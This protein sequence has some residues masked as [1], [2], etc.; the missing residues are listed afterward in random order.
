MFD[1]FGLFA[2]C[3]SFVYAWFSLLS[4][5]VINQRTE[6]YV[7]RPDLVPG[8]SDYELAHAPLVAT[9]ATEVA[10][11]DRQEAGV[12]QLAAAVTRP[13][14]PPRPPPISELIAKSR[15]LSAAPAVSFRWTPVEVDAGAPLNPSEHNVEAM[16]NLQHM[17][18]LDLRST[19]TSL[20]L[21][22]PSIARLLTHPCT[23]PLR[24]FLGGVI[25]R[26]MVQLLEEHH[27]SLER[28]WVSVPRT[29]DDQLA[30]L[31]L[32][33]KLPSLTDL[34]LTRATYG[35]NAHLTALGNCKRLTSLGLR[36]N[37]SCVQGILR[38]LQ[39]SGSR[40]R[41]LRLINTTV[42]SGWSDCFALV[43]TL[44]LL[45]LDR[46]SRPDEIIRAI[47][48]HCPA[49]HTLQ[50]H[51]GPSTND[52]ASL[53]RDAT[54]FDTLLSSER[55]ATRQLRVTLALE[56]LQS[57]LDAHIASC[58][59]YNFGDQTEAITQEWKQ[60]RKALELVASRH[61]KQIRLRLE[62]VSNN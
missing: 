53:M 2:G 46:C 58:Q 18:E 31:D 30:V 60:A 1:C 21:Q 6:P 23:K 59:R 49:M 10:P 9:L 51:C 11:M 42:A 8:S 52:V 12:N 22:T 32:L 40:L 27:P 29:V 44:E 50:I 36:G 61:P 15:L 37:V 24:S 4:S 25:N 45:C 17:T 38:G 57:L 16:L 14:E 48:T 35:A 26:Q 34:Q 43:P 56:P 3:S 20:G 33:P 55:D 47:D 28:L 5:V 7:R 41:V 62:E 39:T 19:A 13:S 54:L